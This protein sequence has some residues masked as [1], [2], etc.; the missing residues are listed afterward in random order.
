M[1]LKLSAPVGDKKRITKDSDVKMS[2]CADKFS[3]EDKAEVQE[4]I[5]N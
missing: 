5:F 3:F 2:L 4:R 1:A